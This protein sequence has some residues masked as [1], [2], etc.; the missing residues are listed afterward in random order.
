MQFRLFSLHAHL[1]SLGSAWLLS[2]VATCLGLLTLLPTSAPSQDATSVVSFE[3]VLDRIHNLSQGDE[4]KASDWRDPTINAWLSATIAPL[5]DKIATSKPQVPTRIADAR[6]TSPALV[7]EHGLIIHGSLR[8]G[9]IRHSV[10]LCDGDLSADRVEDSIIIA[11]GSVFLMGGSGEPPA[12]AIRSVIAAGSYIY[13]DSL[14]TERSHADGTIVLCR[15]YIDC[16]GAWGSALYAGKEIGG[17]AF[18]CTFINTYFEKLDKPTDDRWLN[19]G[20]TMIE[21]PIKPLKA[22]P[23]LASLTMLAVLRGKVTDLHIKKGGDGPD[24]CGIVFRFDKKRYVALVGQP[25]QDEFGNPVRLLDG[26]RLEHIFADLVA[27]WSV[28]GGES[29]MR[30]QDSL[31]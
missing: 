9:T 11:R 5:L 12:T 28:P 17:Y 18:G 23:E 20:L 27:I 29:V 26:V 7:V 25:I 15:G 24:S 4:W 21:L 13:C 10:I 22:P 6:V 1:F 2:V 8:L 19:A 30:I 14:G 31:E 16:Y 3:D